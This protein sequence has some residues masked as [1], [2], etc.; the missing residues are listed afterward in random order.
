MFVFGA[1]GH[2]AVVVDC[3]LSNNVRV[4]GVFDDDASKHE[5]HLLDRSVVIRG[6]P[7]DS[8]FGVGK[9]VHVALGSNTARRT[10]V[11]RLDAL[12]FQ[13]P[14]VRHSQA[15]ISNY[16]GSIGIGTFVGARVVCEPRV[17]VGKHSILNTG[18]ILTH[19]CVV[20]DFCHIAPGVVLLGGV[21][22]GDNCLVGAN[23]TVL[24]GVKIANNVTIGAGSVVTRDVPPDCILRGQPAR[25]T[26]TTSLQE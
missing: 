15:F 16:C 10:A 1:G 11:A 5:Q 24:P 26:K 12:G 8:L 25:V 17:V 22:V 3:L 4:E 19:D 6:L 9:N 2:A 18:C 21:K 14:A 23:S 13:F 20:G 7:S